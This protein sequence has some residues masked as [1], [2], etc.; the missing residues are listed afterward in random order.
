MKETFWGSLIY[1]NILLQNISFWL[2]NERMWRLIFNSLEQLQSTEPQRYKADTV[3]NMFLMNILDM[4][5]EKTESS[6]S[7]IF[8]SDNTSVML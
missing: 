1:Y 5:Q 8:M 4:F 7:I 6:P 3:Q 2:Q